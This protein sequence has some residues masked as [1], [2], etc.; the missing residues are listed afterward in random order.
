MGSDLDLDHFQNIIKFNNNIEPF[1]EDEIIS[2]PSSR[3]QKLKESKEQKRDKKK[4]V[5]K[6]AN[7][8]AI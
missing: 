2:K 4:R 7:V 8:E 1:D 5:S 6:K 3:K